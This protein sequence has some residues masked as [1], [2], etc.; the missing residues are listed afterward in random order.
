MRYRL[1]ITLLFL[2]IGVT[3]AQQAPPMHSIDKAKWEKAVQGLNYN[4]EPVEV[5][6]PPD[7]LPKFHI[8]PVVA[9]IIG[10]TL[11]GL[12]LLYIIYKLFGK[13]LFSRNKKVPAARITTIEEMEDRPME[14][15]LERFLKEALAARNYKLAV[16]IYYLMILKTLH[17]KEMIV[18]KKNKTNMDYLSE[19]AQHPDFPQLQNNTRIF[20]FVWYGD[21]ALEEGQFNSISG[22]FTGIIEKIS[23][24]K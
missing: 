1:I 10:F 17:E 6:P 15:D 22:A 7:N 8:N 19:M 16:R 14:S 3:R 20:E 24:E 2:W 12:L 5:K 4:E 23:R 11:L 9:R 18:W 21:Q 13:D